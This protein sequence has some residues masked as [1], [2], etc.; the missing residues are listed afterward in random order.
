MENTDTTG[1]VLAIVRQMDDEGASTDELFERLDSYG[2]DYTEA[3]RMI[4]KARSS[5]RLDA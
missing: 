2:F 1:R 5:S 4:F 3:R